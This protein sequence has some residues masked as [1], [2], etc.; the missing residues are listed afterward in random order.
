MPQAIEYWTGQGCRVRACENGYMLTNGTCNINPC[1]GFHCGV[2]GNCE[3]VSANAKCS[4]QG[5][6][7]GDH[8][9]T[10]VWSHR[11]MSHTVLHGLIAT[12]FPSLLSFCPRAHSHTTLLSWDVSP[13]KRLYC[14]L[15]ILISF[16][17]MLASKQNHGRQI[18]CWC[19]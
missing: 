7:T 11:L 9:E 6:W 8:C 17:N 2:H 18:D 4:C 14:F 16:V 10:G 12:I 3:I 1:H 15:A 13:Q 5:T 19:L